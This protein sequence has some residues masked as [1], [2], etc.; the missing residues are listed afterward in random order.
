MKMPMMVPGFS[1][2]GTVV[3]PSEVEGEEHSSRGDY[4]ILGVLNFK[5]H[6][7]HEMKG[8]DTG[9]LIEGFEDY[10]KGQH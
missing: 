4:F 9:Q 5:D 6:M 7:E 10:E 3:F 1:L 8:I 2:S